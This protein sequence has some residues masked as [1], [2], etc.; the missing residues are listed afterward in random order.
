MH[1]L[2]LAATSCSGSTETRALP[3][4]D[5][6][7]D[8]DRPH[9]RLVRADE[10]AREDRRQLRPRAAARAQHGRVR[11]ARD[12]DAARDRARPERRV[13]HP[14]ERRDQ[15]LERRPLLCAA[16]PGDECVLGVD[17]RVQPERHAARAPRTRLRGTGRRSRASRSSCAAASRRT[18][19]RSS[20][21]SVF[22][23]PSGSRDHD[24][25]AAHRVEPAGLRRAEPAR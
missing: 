6:P 10:F 16:V 13:P 11:R 8:A 22:R 12:G 3:E 17:L 23:D 7:A 5:R 25:E 2:A 4:P 18:S 21:S 15:R 24:A 20:R 14:P 9:V 1:V 19:T